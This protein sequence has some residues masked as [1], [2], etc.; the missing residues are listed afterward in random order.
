LTI[1]SSVRQKVIELYKNGKKRHEIEKTVNLSGT[2]ISTGS[3]SNIISEWRE[4]EQPLLPQSSQQ[5][6][7]PPSPSPSPSP[8]ADATSNAGIQVSIGEGSPLLAIGC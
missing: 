6:Q 4:H 8:E 2:K 5:Q 3:I 1:E 7:Q